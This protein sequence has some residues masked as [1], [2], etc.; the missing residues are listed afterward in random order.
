MT[1]EANDDTPLSIGLLLRDLPKLI[2]ALVLLLTGFAYVAVKVRR[3]QWTKHTVQKP[4][5]ATPKER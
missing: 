2:W 3:Q 4:S 1:T 5:M